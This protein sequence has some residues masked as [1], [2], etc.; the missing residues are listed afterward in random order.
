MSTFLA[1]FGYSFK[2]IEMQKLRD[3]LELHAFGVCSAMGER[4]GIASSRIRMWFI[5]ISFLTLGSPV[6]VYMALAFVGALLIGVV[7]ISSLKSIR[8]RFI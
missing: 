6:I 3:F 1:R 7:T 2:H 8:Q 4:L 5:Y